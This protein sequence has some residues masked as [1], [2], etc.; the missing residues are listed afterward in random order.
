MQINLANINIWIVWALMFVVRCI[1]PTLIEC[2]ICG[3]LYRRK[4]LIKTKQAKIKH[5]G[6]VLKTGSSQ[7]GIDIVKIHDI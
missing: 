6:S 4:E 5:H 3:S 1:I 7:F 2:A